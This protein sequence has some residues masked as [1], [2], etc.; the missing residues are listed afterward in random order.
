MIPCRRMLG[1]AQKGRQC[2][3]AKKLGFDKAPVSAAVVQHEFSLYLFFDFSL[4]S[5]VIGI[6][7]L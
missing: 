5:F 7:I 3:S 2:N 1:P 6:L 4:P